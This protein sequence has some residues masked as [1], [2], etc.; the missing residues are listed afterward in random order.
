MSER[1]RA[2]MVVGVGVVLCA[3]SCVVRR[4]VRSI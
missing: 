2:G 4:R 3:R 1:K